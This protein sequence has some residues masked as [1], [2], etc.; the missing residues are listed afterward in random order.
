M[1]YFLC[2]YFFNFGA[3]PTIYVQKACQTYI[4][5]KKNDAGRP[6]HFRTKRAAQ[7]ISPR[8]ATETV[9]NLKSYSSI[10]RP[11]LLGYHKPTH[12][13]FSTIRHKHA[14]R[15]RLPHTTPKSSS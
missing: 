9:T 10:R 1:I 15:L 12:P 5:C 4:V 3:L 13:P 6:N 7:G 2:G 11:H 8:T 14:Q